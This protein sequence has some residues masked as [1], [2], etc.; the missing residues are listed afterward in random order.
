MSLARAAGLDVIA[1]RLDMPRRGAWTASG[2]LDVGN[3][4]APTGRIELEFATPAPATFSGTIVPPSATSSPVPGR[5]RFFLR[6]GAAGMG[7]TLSGLPYAEVAPLLVVQDIVG[8]AG[9]AIGSTAALGGL[10]ARLLW[11]RA[12]GAAGSALA[13]FLGPAALT[14][15]MTPAGLVDVVQ[16]TWPAYTGTPLVER[17]PDE[18]G[19]CVL[20]LDSPDL[21]P[22][23]SLFGRHVER[24]VHLIRPDGKFRTEAVLDV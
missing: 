9:E 3:D 19:R 10:T 20:A 21:F 7:A 2:E 5:A 6:A 23:M 13:R 15:R 12:A 18:L 24:V 1:L 17:E 11:L 16:E 22:G 14:W 4:A 8:S